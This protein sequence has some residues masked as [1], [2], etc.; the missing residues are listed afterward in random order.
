M[1]PRA[2]LEP[3]QALARRILSPL[4]LPNS[5]TPARIFQKFAQLLEAAPGFEPGIKDLQSHA[6]PLGY[7]A[8]YFFPRLSS[9]SS[10]CFNSSVETTGTPSIDSAYCS[11]A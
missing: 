5:A 8:S 9:L 2:G 7:A 10:S 1:V 4:R 11:F 3:A 6:L